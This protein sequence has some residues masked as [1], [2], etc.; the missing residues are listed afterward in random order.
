MSADLPISP[1]KAVG[2]LF[3]Y[4][5]VVFEL[6][7]PLGLSFYLSVNPISPNEKLGVALLL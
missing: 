6:H 5:E 2:F 4:F 3:K 7:Y 1:F